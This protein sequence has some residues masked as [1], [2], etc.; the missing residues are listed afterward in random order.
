M[1]SEKL[2]SMPGFTCAVMGESQ[3]ISNIYCADLLSWAMSRAPQ[4]C[5][6][7]TVMGNINMLAV[8]SLA[9]VAAVV[10]CEGALLDDDAAVRAKQMNISIFTTALPAFEA[11]LAIAKES[12]FLE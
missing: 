2:A 8:A 6:W 9:E 4:N 5:V 12:D 11:G 1:K 10:L 7:C 3:E